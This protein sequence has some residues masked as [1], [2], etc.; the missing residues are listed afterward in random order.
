M[1]RQLWEL[2]Q[3]NKPG[4]QRLLQWTIPASDMD[5]VF[6]KLCRCDGEVNGQ[7]SMQLALIGPDGQNSSLHDQVF[8]SRTPDQRADRRSALYVEIHALPL[9]YCIPQCVRGRDPVRA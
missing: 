9:S 4:K 7:T 1:D 5:T 8:G 6:K 3:S 2:Y